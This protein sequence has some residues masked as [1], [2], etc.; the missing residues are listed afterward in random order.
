MVLAKIFNVMVPFTYRSAVNQLSSIPPTFP[1]VAVAL[2]GILR[3]CTSFLTD[4]RDTVFVPASQRASNRVAL[5]IFEHL[6]SLSLRFHLTRETGAVLRGF[7]RGMNAVG[8]VGCCGRRAVASV[9][10]RQPPLRDRADFCSA[11]CSSTSAAGGRWR[12]RLIGRPADRADAAGDRDGGCHPH[13]DVSAWRLLVD[14]LIGSLQCR[15]LVLADYCGHGGRL[16]RLHH[17]RH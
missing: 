9:A 2:Y 12:W 1:Y 6:H 14:R 4:F 5:T 10:D 17:Q 16:H 8:S 7:E 11:F 3:L 15:L 13:R